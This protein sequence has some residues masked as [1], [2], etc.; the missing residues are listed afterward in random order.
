MIVC[1]CNALNDRDV[2]EAAAAGAQR[3]CDVYAYH[4][5]ERACG[6]CGDEMRFICSQAFT[7][8]LAMGMASGQVSAC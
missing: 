5:C 1:I 6:K 8:K 4:G 7:G 2:L 3:P